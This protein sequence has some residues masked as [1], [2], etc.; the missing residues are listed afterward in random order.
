MSVR[1]SCVG[2]TMNGEC[3]LAG[4]RLFS[5]YF[6]DDASGA[7]SSG[8][9]LNQELGAT[10]EAIEDVQ[11]VRRTARQTAHRSIVTSSTGRI[12]DSAAMDVLRATGYQL[13][14]SECPFPW[15]QAAFTSA[16]SAPTENNDQTALRR[17]YLLS[18]YQ[19]EVSNTTCALDCSL[20]RRSSSARLTGW[21]R[22]CSPA[23]HCP[24][25]RPT[26]RSCH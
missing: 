21:R 16:G 3:T 23:G 22:T 19:P 26:L 7:E 11:T 6:N 24:T 4:H 25:Y 17:S 18:L 20:T 12:I 2:L 13:A 10:R 14:A 5:C 15:L 9:A 1:Q 8:S